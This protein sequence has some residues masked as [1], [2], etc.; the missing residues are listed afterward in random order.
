MICSCKQFGIRY[1]VI[2]NHA[3]FNCKFDVIDYQHI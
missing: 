1:N 3:I 2:A